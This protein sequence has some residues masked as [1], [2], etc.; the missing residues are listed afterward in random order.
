MMRFF[1]F[2]PWRHTAM[3]FKVLSVQQ[4]TQLLLLKWTPESLPS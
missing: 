4:C 2:A 3:W 1:L